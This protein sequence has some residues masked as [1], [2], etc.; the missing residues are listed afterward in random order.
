MND[1]HVPSDG[2]V[3]VGCLST[4]SR[5]QTPPTA[6]TPAVQRRPVA[7]ARWA[8][9]RRI[10]GARLPITSTARSERRIAVRR[11]G[12]GID[13]SSASCDPARGPWRSTASSSQ[14]PGT[15]RSSTLPRSSKPD[16]GLI[17]PHDAT[18]RGELLEEGLVLG[19]GPEDLHLADHRRDEDELDRPV[20]DHLIRQAEIAAPCVQR[21]RHGMSVLLSSATTPDFGRSCVPLDGA[22]HRGGHSLNGHDHI[23]A[24]AAGNYAVSPSACVSVILAS[25][26]HEKY[27]W[28]LSCRSRRRQSCPSITRRQEAVLQRQVICPS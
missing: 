25:R 15:P 19:H 16:P 27:P 17:E 2:A 7:G 4:M 28:Y 5:T 23:P 13:A 21:F 26:Y 20:A 3:V 1:T 8:I 22:H 24:D 11:P 6:L 12:V 18:E 14:V 10:H 9:P